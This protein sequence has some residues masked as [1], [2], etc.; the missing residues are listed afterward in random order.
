MAWR[1]HFPIRKYDF[2]AF[3]GIAWVTCLVRIKSQLFRDDSSFRVIFSEQGGYLCIEEHKHRAK[4]EETSFL[5]NAFQI[6]RCLHI[7]G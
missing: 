2:N 7:I 5:V 1:F 6:T 3:P 4:I